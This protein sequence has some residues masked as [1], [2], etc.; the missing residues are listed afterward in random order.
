MASLPAHAHEMCASSPTRMAWDD[1]THCAAA[2]TVGTGGT[3][4]FCCLTTA[5][6]LQAPMTG[7]LSLRGITGRLSQL[8]ISIMKP[9][10]SWKKIWSTLMPPSSTHRCTYG[11]PI[12]FSRRSTATMLSHCRC[13]HTCMTCQFI[14]QYGIRILSIDRRYY[15]ANKIKSYPPR[16]ENST[17]KIISTSFP[18]SRSSLSLS[19]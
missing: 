3:P 11:M 14:A 1:G 18:L 16:L 5:A 15:W 2:V 10:G 8:H 4:V 17:R 6:R 19:S 9:S 7:A 13:T 12:S